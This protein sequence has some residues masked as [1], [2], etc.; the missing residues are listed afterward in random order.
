VISETCRTQDA[1]RNVFRIL[2]AK[3]KGW[4]PLGNFVSL[5]GKIK[6]KLIIK[7]CGVRL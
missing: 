3:Y 4:G 2:V 5:D 6:P 7:E 1:K